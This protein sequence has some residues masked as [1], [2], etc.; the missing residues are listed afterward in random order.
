MSFCLRDVL[1]TN[2]GPPGTP[3]CFEVHYI[4]FV[5]CGSILSAFFPFSLSPEERERFKHQLRREAALRRAK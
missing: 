1:S 3:S 4:V 5:C 2:S